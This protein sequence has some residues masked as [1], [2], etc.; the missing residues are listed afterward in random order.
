MTELNGTFYAQSADGSLRKLEDG[1]AIY[2]DESVI[3]D[4]E[5]LAAHSV[6]ISLE[7]AELNVLISG[8]QA[9]LFDG[10]LQPVSFSELETAANVDTLATLVK[11]YVD[12]A[13]IETAAGIDIAES[14]EQPGAEFA[15]HIDRIV[16]V[17]AELSENSQVYEVGTDLNNVE[18]ALTTAAAATEATPAESSDVVEDEEEVTGREEGFVPPPEPEPEPEP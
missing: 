1:D 16:D 18:E 15:E 6:N 13:D 8:T 12:P 11:A 3:G 4:R 9:Q 2:K 17:E 10:S 14:T 5:N 7:D